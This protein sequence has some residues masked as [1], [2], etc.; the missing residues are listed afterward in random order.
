MEFMQRTNKIVLD[1]SKPAYFGDDEE[2]QDD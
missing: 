1:E 2:W